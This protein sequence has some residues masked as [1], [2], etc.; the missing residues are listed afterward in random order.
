MKVLILYTT[1]GCHLCDEAKAMAWPVLAH[2]DY[3][4]QEV[5]ITDDEALVERYGIRIPV[6][7]R[8]ESSSELG[9]PFSQQDLAEYLHG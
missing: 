5:E 3:Q 1:L 8:P 9:W 7:K 2:Y 6:V 4:L